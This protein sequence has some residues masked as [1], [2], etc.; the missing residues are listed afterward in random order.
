MCNFF[1]PPLHWPCIF[2]IAHSSSSPTQILISLLVSSCSIDTHPPQ[3]SRQWTHPALIKRWAYPWAADHGNQPCWL[4]LLWILDHR[5]QISLW[6]ILLHFPGKPALRKPLNLLS[7]HSQLM[8]WPI[9]QREYRSNY[10]RTTHH[11]IAKSTRP[12]VSVRC[13]YLPFSNSDELPLLLSKSSCPT[14][15]LEPSSLHQLRYFAPIIIPSFPHCQISFTA[16]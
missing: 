5:S 2:F 14:C 7:C 12:P 1:G 9:F 11:F 3:S 16:D 8:T 4:V 10:T 13:L 6:K 15:A